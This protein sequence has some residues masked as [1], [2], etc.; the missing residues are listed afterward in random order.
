MIIIKYVIGQDSDWLV[1]WKLYI[2]KDMTQQD[3]N[4]YID[5]VS[6]SVKIYVVF[7]VRYGTGKFKQ[8]LTGKDGHIK[9][10]RKVTF[11]S[12]FIL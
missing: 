1:K 6:T 11:Q 12:Q 9:Q 4:R 8:K 3:N 2:L 7:H 5:E 10:S